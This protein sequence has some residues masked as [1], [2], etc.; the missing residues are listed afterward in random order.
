MRL[1]QDIFSDDGMLLLRENI[2][3]TSSLI[4]RLQTTGVPYVYVQDE[5]TEGI[6]LKD[7]ISPETRSEGLR[8]ITTNF[9]KLVSNGTTKSKKQ[10]PIYVGKEFGKA[11][12][13]VLEDLESNKDALI[14]VSNIHTTDTYLFNHSL[15]VTIYTLILAIAN[16]YSGE[17]LRTIGLGTILHDIGKMY[18]PLD[19]LNKPGKLTDEEFA[20]MKKHTTYGFEMLKDE[21]NIPLLAAHCAFQHHERLDGSGY[22]RGLKQDEI[23]EF[24]KMIAIADS[25]DAMTTNRVYRKAMQPSDALENLYTGA[26][27]L[28]DISLL[29]SFRDKVAIYPIGVTVLLSNGVTG[30]VADINSDCPHRPIIRVIKDE[31]GQDLTQPYELDMSKNL[32]VVVKEIL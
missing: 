19:I 23:H 20:E 31:Y 22:P 28:Y 12:D 6:V 32:S 25:Y 5:R 29:S 9:K 30:V 16:G 8:I 10:L 26:G 2:E 15:N 27:K 3:L 7:A 21:P 4:S 18:I 11:I 14:M 13:M 24:A 1:A 17:K